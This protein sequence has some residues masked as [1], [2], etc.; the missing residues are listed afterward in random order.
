MLPQSSIILQDGSSPSSSTGTPGFFWWEYDGSIDGSQATPPFNNST[1]AGW[2]DL[3]SV[4][5]Q[6]FG[7]DEN[8]NEAG[9]GNPLPIVYQM[10]DVR[11]AITTTGNSS[12]GDGDPSSTSQFPQATTNLAY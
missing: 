1:S 3:F 8:N 5:G 2:N 6:Y 12:I 9:N 11:S 7:A 10:L 4:T